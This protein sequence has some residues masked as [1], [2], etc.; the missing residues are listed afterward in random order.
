[1]VVPRFVRQAAQN[2]PITVY[3][4]GSQRRSFTWVMDVVAAL[5]SLIQLPEAHGEVINLGHYK[6]IS[7]AELAALVREMSG[8]ESEIVN[9]PYEEAFSEGF[10]DV[11]RRLPDLSKIREL[12]GYSPSLD[13]REMIG[14][15][16]ETPPR[17]DLR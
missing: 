4:D 8:S 11:K 2:E 17:Q 13:L 14:S 10:E 5:I 1:M 3:G 9:V 7:I 6:D 12:I 15:I 16:I